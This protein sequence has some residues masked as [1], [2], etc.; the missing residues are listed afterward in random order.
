ME[1][2]RKSLFVTCFWLFTYFYPT[3]EFIL[4]VGFF[5][6]ADT[7]T[8]V[9]AAN[10]RGDAIV[11]KRFSDVIRKF[12]VY[13]IAVLVAHVIQK[14][15]F[16]EFPSMKIITGLIAFNELKSIDENIGQI[17]GFSLFEYFI[18]KLR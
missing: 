8:G 14:N 4:L 7:I 13:G 5:I 15:F 2:I 12:V 1:V 18:K 6:V 16:V 10:K 9:I 17:S 3:F 11:S